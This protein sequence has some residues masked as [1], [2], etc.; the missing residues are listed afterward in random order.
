MKNLGTFPVSFETLSFV[1]IIDLCFEK[2]AGAFINVLSIVLP[3]TA[4]DL[5][6]NNQ[7]LVSATVVGLSFFLDVFGLDVKDIALL[8]NRQ[9]SSHFPIRALC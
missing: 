2:V 8:T 1:C 7:V 6:S 5:L 3:F 9:T 4:K